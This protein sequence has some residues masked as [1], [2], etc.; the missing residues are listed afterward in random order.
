MFE[1]KEIVLKDGY[2]RGLIVCLILSIVLIAG[3]LSSKY[4]LPDDRVVLHKNQDTRL[5]MGQIQVYTP[6]YYD[7][8]TDKGMIQVRFFEKHQVKNLETENKISYA[9]FDETGK[10]LPY[11]VTSTSCKVDEENINLCNVDVIIQAVVPD[12]FYGVIYQIM[13]E[14]TSIETVQVDYRE[15]RHKTFREKGENYY[16]E[17]EVLEKLIIDYKEQI[18]QY[19]GE[20]QSLVKSKNTSAAKNKRQE[21]LDLY[22][23]IGEL[24]IA[25][26]RAL[27]D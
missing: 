20:W 18:D 5:Y 14:D 7:Y 17:I 10:K 24:K 27:L 16:P 9:V 8:D 3:F 22:A 13:Q 12:N 19:Y 1:N 15:V 21:I 6:V 23:E 4:L 26:G 11:V 25:K 2:N